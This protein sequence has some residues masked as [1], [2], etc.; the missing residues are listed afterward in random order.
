MALWR[1]KRRGKVAKQY[2]KRCTMHLRKLILFPASVIISA[3]NL[4]L[5]TIPGKKIILTC[6]VFFIFI[7]LNLINNCYAHAQ[8]NKTSDLF[9][10]LAKKI[11]N[12]TVC[13]IEYNPSKTAAI[14]NIDCGSAIY[15]NFK[16]KQTY[17]ITD[18][19]P[20]LV[21]PTWVNNTIVTVESSCGTGCAKDIIFVAPSTVISCADHE[22]RIKNL[23]KTEPPD[24]YNNR[25]LL[26]D[27]KK[28]IYVC[29][30]DKN[31]IQVLPLVKHTSIRP[32]R[33]YFSEK[34]EIRHNHLVIAYKN[35]DGKIKEDDYGKI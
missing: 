28:E 18:H 26:I 4:I 14:A 34:A 21:F 1:I 15:I 8:Q 25:P 33:G 19:R 7:S 30:D 32:P 17:T 9:N 12:H 27:P 22:Y 2:S 13:G 6:Q 31:N 5:N 16:T 11:R 24:F 35:K 29:Y 20:G 10:E 23:I 3:G